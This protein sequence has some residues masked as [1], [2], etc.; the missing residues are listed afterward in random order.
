M[1]SDANKL[2]K[3][4]QDYSGKNAGIAEKS[5]LKTFEILFVDTEFKIISKLKDFSKIYV[6]IELNKQ[7]LSEIYTPD[8]PIKNHGVFPDYAI[9]NTE[10]NKTIYIE[11]KRQ[12]GW[13]E[14]KK[15]SDGR[16]NA[17]ERS[18]KF[19][20]PGLQ[21]ILR[22][23]GN[24]G[25]DVLPFWTV[26]QGDITRD[27]CRVR[28]ISLWFDNYTNHYFFW[29]NGKDPLPLLEHFN[30]NLKHLLD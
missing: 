13:V 30:N 25:D 10:T 9:T 11:V 26:F 28:E 12:D 6:A 20:S 24:L 5:F 16:G 27:P 3:K 17:H 7:E 19:F 29:R 8:K 14:N 2:R 15:R 4:W 18:C 1:G 22:E 21:K 23:R